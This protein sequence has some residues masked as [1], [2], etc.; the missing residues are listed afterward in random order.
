LHGAE[1]A[2]CMSWRAQGSSQGAWSSSG[3]SRV[4]GDKFFSTCSCS[5]FSTF[6]ILM[7]SSPVRESFALLLVTYVGLSLSV[8]CLLLAIVTFL[9]CRC[10]WSISTSLHLQLSICLFT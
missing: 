1:E 5:H 8:L 6:A 3:C 10:L 2:H 9:L 7:A 4:T